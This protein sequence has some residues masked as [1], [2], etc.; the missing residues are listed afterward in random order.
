MPQIK[1]KT[2][3]RLNVTNLYIEAQL[4]GQK[5]TFI[6]EGRK[7][8]ILLPTKEAANENRP[9]NDTAHAVEYWSAT[10]E[11]TTYSINQVDIEIEIL[12]KISIPEVA[13]SHPPTQYEAFTKEEQLTAQ[14]ITKQHSILAER[15][16]EYWLEILRWTSGYALIG[17]PAIS[18]VQS[19]WATY[20]CSEEE[21]KRVWGGSR[22]IVVPWNP[23]VKLLAWESASQKLVN[24]EKLPIHLRFLH[25][26]EN[27][28]EHQQIEKSV[29]ET[30]MACET[31]LRYT[32][33]QSIPTSLQNEIT[34]YIEEANIN[35]Y[36]TQFF[37]SLI[38]ENQAEKY[39]E[40]SRE[41]SSLFSRRNSYIHMGIIPQTDNA[42]CIEFIRIAKSLF[43]IFDNKNH[44]D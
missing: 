40:I 23:P 24:N 4:I 30:A 13:L 9:R 36:V 29:I 37:K 22:P 8:C 6:F 35:K 10:N 44:V 41:L 42:R 7:T 43:A 18:S 38:P 26:A 17:K 14:E 5:H 34:K 21:N 28:I 33:L 31:F 32:V 16:L 19:G 3:N 27:S 15:A 39:K 25:E 1:A 20:I 12:G 2:W 11:P